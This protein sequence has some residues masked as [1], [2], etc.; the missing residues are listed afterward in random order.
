V[1]RGY[2]APYARAGE[3][4]AIGAFVRDIPMR[5]GHPSW[6]LLGAIEAALPRFADR[7]AAIAWGERDWCF[8]SAFR[9][10]WQR[11]LPRA[12]VR[13]EP[14]AGHWVLEDAGERVLPWLRGFLADHPVR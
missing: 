8:T 14:E 9:A 2:L 5:A 10:E 7:P 11:R 6:A 3:R 12:S 1:R 13:A 4:A